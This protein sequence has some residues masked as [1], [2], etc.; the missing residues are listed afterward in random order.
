MNT[1][2][3]RSR[4][5]A[6]I[7]AGTLL[8]VIVVLSLGL[9]TYFIYDEVFTDQ[10]I[11]FQGADSWYHIRAIEH[12]IE[13]FPLRITFD[14]YALFPGGQHVAV[15][16]LYDLLIAGLA[17]L[18][19][20][21]SPSTELTYTIAAW[22]P[23]VLGS[24]VVL[25]VYFITKLL[26]D[27]RAGL[28]AAIWIAILPGAF[29]QHS[30]LSYVDHHIA[31][32]FFAGMTML[33]MLLS[34]Q[35]ERQHDGIKPKTD[36]QSFKHR[37]RLFL[38][39]AI[40]G[41]WLGCYL[42]TWVGGSL[43]V[44]ILFLF[45]LMQIF[46]EYL[47]RGDCTYIALN[48][49]PVCIIALVMVCPFHSLPQFQYHIVSLVGTL[50]VIP[51]CCW[52]TS[53]FTHGRTSR[54]YFPV[55]VILVGIAS[56]GIFRVVAPEIFSQIIWSVNYFLT[57]DHGQ[58]VLEATPLFYPDGV[59]TLVPAWK[60]F[61]IGSLTILLALIILIYKLIKEGS[62]VYTLILVWT[63]M[64]ILLTLR[65]QRFAYYLALNVAILSGFFWSHVAIYLNGLIDKI[66]NPNM[67]RR[68]ILSVIIPIVVLL[69]NISPALHIAKAHA[70]PHP[71]WFPAMKWLQE[72]TPEPFSQNNFY[73]ESY[74][75][76]ES[77]HRYP[78]PESAYGIMNWWDHGYW[79]QQISRRIPVANPTQSGA[80]ESADFFVSQDEDDA[81]RIMDQLGARYVITEYT[82]PVWENQEI[83]EL[84]GKFGRIIE[85][86]ERDRSDF[87]EVYYALDDDGHFKP[88]FF[89]YPS[90]Y[91]SML[92]RLYLFAGQAYTPV[93]TTW[94]IQYSNEIDASGQRFKQLV[95]SLR[96]K[97]YMAAEDF[98]AQQPSDDWRIAGLHFSQ[99]CVPLE[100]LDHYQHVYSSPTEVADGPNGKIAYIEIFEKID[101]DKP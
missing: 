88:M 17:I 32:G 49:V 69:P 22:F 14:P 23:A 57:G 80:R 8:L 93:N 40:A 76:P 35:K 65:Q 38:L 4:Q 68:M 91:R 61:T 98:V 48:I 53:K 64:M 28:I 39:P 67:V 43:F 6:P 7:I 101:F 36:H 54:K 16:P 62:C 95:T 58:S 10:Y 81:N 19:G 66:L 55:V 63:V 79:I 86:A 96:F 59:F 90:Y 29:F 31:E 45:M 13:Q 82:L 84:F 52:L 11:N 21:G 99:S 26:L 94:V 9:R 37:I 100:K 89:F 15:A 77:E 3:S 78:Y 2:L 73:T 1:D 20:L 75:S 25:P 85:W 33:F 34:L 72:N 27:H 18:I 83:A 60:M 74:Q 70:G 92:T 50:V 12:L 42:L 44:L 97:T 41:F 30:V 5:P 51:C 56:I 87:Y 46:I 47:K 71:D 24:L